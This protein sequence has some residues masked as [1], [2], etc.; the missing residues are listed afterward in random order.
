[1]EKKY[2]FLLIDDDTIFNFLTRKTLQRANVSDSV[3]DFT[4]ARAAL[5]YL[6][7]KDIHK[8]T[9]IILLDIN[10][11]FMNGFEFLD[12]FSTLNFSGISVFMLTSSLDDRDRVK[13]LKYNCVKGFFSKP[14]T[15]DMIMNICD[16]NSKIK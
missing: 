2:N 15:V 16:I 5:D 1:M 11:P 10:M 8:S 14:I 13:A 4:D 12:I 3:V 7:E 6:K 9:D